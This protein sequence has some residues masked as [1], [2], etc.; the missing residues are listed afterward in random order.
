MNLCSDITFVP[1]DIEESKFMQASF[2]E[3]ISE[4]VLKVALAQKQLGWRFYL[5]N[6]NR[7]YCNYSY[8][9]ITIPTWVVGKNSSHKGYSDWY[10]SHELAHSIAGAFA[11]HGPQFMSTLK[12]ICPKESIEYELEYKPRNAKAAGIGEITLDDI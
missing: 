11:K 3:Q 9:V 8:K 5:I 10:L 4:S 12:A 6:A 2:W 7:G 1:K